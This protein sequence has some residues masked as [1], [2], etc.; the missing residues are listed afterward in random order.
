M[1]RR[2]FVR[3][4]A[5]ALLLAPWKPRARSPDSQAPRQG[6]ICASP[7]TFLPVA[8]GRN[9]GLSYQGTH[10]L[11]YGALREVA[12][13]FA[14][15]GR[16]VVAVRG[17]GCDDGIAGVRRGISDLG[18]LCCP[19]KGSAAED[20]ASLLVAYD[21]KAVVVHPANPLSAVG[22]EDLKAIARGRIRSWK[23]LGWEDNP[24]AQV[25]RRHCPDY[26]EPVR[27]MLLGD[28]A[29]WSERS[30]FVDTDEQIVNLVSRFP[31]SIG[32]VS[33]VFAR[34]LVERRQLRALA[35][36]GRRPDTDPRRYPIRGPLSL[37]F[38]AGDLG[39]MSEFLDFLYGPAGRA[40]IARRLIPVSAQE[41]GYRA[42]AA[43]RR[44]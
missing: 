25:V 6:E 24:V 26:A 42:G 11:A 8:A 41:A 7:A 19:V 40:V 17:G 5:G 31:R 34:P 14:E 4:L 33:W 12:R 9:S 32:V 27:Q 37:V 15:S 36:E 43:Y 2:A 29:E 13:S 23:E 35:V 38:R 21:L 16:G 28:R 22:M 39:R 30:L 1:D 18:G 3:I 44:M 20:L 10:I